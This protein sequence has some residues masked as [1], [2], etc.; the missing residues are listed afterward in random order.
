MV[1]ARV[2]ELLHWRDVEQY[3]FSYLSLLRYSR[4]GLAYNVMLHLE[5]NL[6]DGSYL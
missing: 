2:I 6:T 1:G 4:T 3:S 5:M